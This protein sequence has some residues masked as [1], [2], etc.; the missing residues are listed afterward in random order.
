MV[1][2]SFARRARPLVLACLCVFVIPVAGCTTTTGSCEMVPVTPVVHS[3]L[4]LPSTPR[5]PAANV[6]ACPWWVDANGVRFTDTRA[7][8][9]S[10]T[11]TITPADL[12][13]IGHAT[14][15]AAVM[16]AFKDDTVY[17]I[18]DV[19]PTKAVAM[20]VGE[21]QVTVLLGASTFPIGLCAFL[22]GGPPD[23]SI[24]CP[25]PS[26]TPPPEPGSSPCAPD[27]RRAEES[28]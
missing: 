23:R 6:G 17:Q 2:G 11:W 10:P 15:R 7:S 4:F 18:A 16:P 22:P 3:G 9:G 19:D 25:R 21:G 8:W 5:P 12:R 28:G 27:C 1:L 24:Q 20:A 13:P 14:A 26:G